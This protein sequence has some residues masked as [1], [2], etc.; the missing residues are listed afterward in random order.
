[1]QG[2]WGF[3]EL[4]EMRPMLAVA[5]AVWVIA[6]VCLHELSHGVAAIKLGDNTPIYTGHMTWN[7]LVHMGRMSLIMFA[8][9]GLAWGMM[10]VTPSRRGCSTGTGM[11]SWRSRGRCATRCCSWC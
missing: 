3:A 1:M 10:P 8:L 7:P 2:G 4:W 9:V 11:R 5:W 6:S